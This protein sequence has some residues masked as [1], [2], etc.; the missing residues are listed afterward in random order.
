MGVSRRIVGI[1]GV[2]TLLAGSGAGYGQAARPADPPALRGVDRIVCLGDS[3][4]QGG[5]RPGGYV[6]LLERCLEALLG[7]KVEVINAGISGHKSNDMLA[8]FQ[9]DVLD[10]KPQLVTVSVGINDVWHGFTPEHPAG[11]GPRRVPPAEFQSN[12]EYLLAAA[13]RAGVRVALFTTTLFEESPD[14][15]RNRR[16]ALYNAIIQSLASRHGAL[17]VD[18]NASFWRAATRPGAEKLTTDQV[19]L[20]IAGNR[21]MAHTVLVSLG[22]LPDQVDRATEQVRAARE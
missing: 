11:Y 1:L 12:L 5:G 10:R 4:T 19:H 3:I 17:L 8:R 22:F 2:S 18:Q 21:L 9:R 16:I 7:R 15:P 20:S 14:S 13:E 6:W